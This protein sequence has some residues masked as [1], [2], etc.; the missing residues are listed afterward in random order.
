M[1]LNISTNT[2]LNFSGNDAFSFVDSLISNSIAES[3]YKF[4]YLL[5][6]DGKVMFWFICSFSNQEFKMFQSEEVLKKMMEVFNKYK[7]RID[8]NIEI[9][10]EV[11]NFKIEV[12][13][14]KLN[15]SQ[16]NKLE[17]NNSWEEVGLTLALPLNK[18]I[19]IGV[20]PNEIN[21][22]ESFVNY[23]KGCF[24]GQEQT[25]RIKFRGKP[26]RILKTLPNSVQ[27]LV[28]I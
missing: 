8:C 6:P 22:L 11:N 19:D 20:L 24:I 4:S 1:K 13:G 23:D 18:I 5:G 12:D 25:S 27:E 2:F 9:F 21:W 14:D 3:E 10:K 16:S 7:I 28:K 17:N 15:I 26:R